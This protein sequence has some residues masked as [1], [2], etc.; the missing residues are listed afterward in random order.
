MGRSLIV[1]MGNVKKYRRKANWN[2]LG[3]NE[4]DVEA[5]ATDFPPAKRTK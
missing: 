1:P 3:W 2:H 4:V 5:R